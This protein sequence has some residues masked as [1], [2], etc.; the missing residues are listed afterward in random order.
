MTKTDKSE[1]QAAMLRV[2]QLSFALTE[3]NLYLDSHPTCEKGIAYF[4]KHKEALDKAKA[5]YENKYG[6]LCIENALDENDKK[7]KWV[8]EPFPWVSE[9]ERSEG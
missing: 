8:C 1:R 5:E 7:W 4:K 6:A 2:Q 9:Y 3:A